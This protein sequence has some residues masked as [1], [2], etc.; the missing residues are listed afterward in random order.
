MLILTL[1]L[2]FLVTLKHSF[3]ISGALI[4][5]ILLLITYK[6]KQIYYFLFSG[7]IFFLIFSFPYF[8]KNYLFYG[9]PISPLLEI[10]KVNYNQDIVNFAESIKIADKKLNLNN[11]GIF[12]LNFLI[13]VSFSSILNFIGVP[14]L[15]VLLSFNFYNYNFRYLLFFIIFYLIIFL[16]LGQNSIRYY[17]DFV[18]SIILIIKLNLNLIKNSKILNIILI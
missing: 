2:S 7:L 12:I 11:F 17:L 8:F 3:I 6:K 4:N 14:A 5:S 13:P 1:S 10:Y 18:F 16:I 15:L 9:D